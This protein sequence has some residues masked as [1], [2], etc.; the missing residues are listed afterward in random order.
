MLA[1]HVGSRAGFEMRQQRRGEREGST[2]LPGELRGNGAALC[3]L[4]S[5][6][7]AARPGPGE[8]RGAEGA[9]REAQEAAE[10]PREGPESCHRAQ[11]AATGPR[12]RGRDTESCPRERPERRGPSLSLQIGLYE[13][14]GAAPS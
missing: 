13:A 3:R 2:G 5:G 1:Q 4:R 11:R 8:P 6:G 14:G 7:E 9:V 12:Y 10:D